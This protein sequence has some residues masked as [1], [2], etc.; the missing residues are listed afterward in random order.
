MPTDYPLIDGHAHD[1]S[2]VEIAVS[3]DEGAPRI[4]NGISEVTYNQSLEPGVVRGTSSQPLAFTKGVLAPGEGSLVMP[5]ED[6]QDLRDTLG[7]GYMEV[8]FSI[9]ISYG[10]LNRPT[11]T[12]ILRG[13]R[14]TDDESTGS[15]DSEDPISDTLSIKYLTGSRGGI[16]PIKNMLQ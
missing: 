8:Q 12:D 4:F 10:A 15:G 11:I 2:S 1:F 6:A 5:K 9:T 3:T 14:I 7:D 13:V 16:N